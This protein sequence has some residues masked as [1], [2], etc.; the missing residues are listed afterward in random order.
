ML[1]KHEY[2]VSKLKD[3][4]RTTALTSQDGL[5][6]VLSDF[7]ELK[8]SPL[9][10]LLNT[11]DESEEPTWLIDTPPTKPSP[12]LPIPIIISGLGLFA[13]I[14]GILCALISI[15][16]TKEYKPQINQ[17]KALPQKAP[18]PQTAQPTQAVN[19]AQEA[20]QPETPQPKAPQ[21]QAEPTGEPQP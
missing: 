6:V 17:Q 20:Q 9:D 11:P 12:G 15:P 8:K 1:P 14:V 19:Q 10:I 2:Y 4:L 18:L 16:H 5:R 3:Y 7:A 13:I 21:Q